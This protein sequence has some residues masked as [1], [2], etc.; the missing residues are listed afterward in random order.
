M[1]YMTIRDAYPR[2]EELAG[3]RYSPAYWIPPYFDAE[4]AQEAQDTGRIDIKLYE[5]GM[6]IL[7]DIGLGFSNYQT[8]IENVQG[9]QVHS[10]TDLVYIAD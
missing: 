10:G 7:E 9:W 4:T 6:R 2:R 1:P 3:R 5:P 8:K